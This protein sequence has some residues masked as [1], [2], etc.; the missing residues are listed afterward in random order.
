MWTI[1]NNSQ[2][3]AFHS[4]FLTRRLDTIATPPCR[5]SI[6]VDDINSDDI[7]EST[8]DEDD[9]L[10]FEIDMEEGETRR[11]TSNN[12]IHTKIK[13]GAELLLYHRRLGH[14]S[15][16]KLQDMARLGMIP[17][18]LSNV[19]FP[20]CPSCMYGKLSRKP[21]RNSHDYRPISNTETP[22]QFVSVDQ[23]D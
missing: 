13:H 22:G 21:W 1:P 23:M 11:T 17:K 5:P 8:D 4:L 14:V 7:M 16:A 9:L 3:Y 15:F 18:H 20:L 19:Q 10:N 12:M 6:Y 2:Y